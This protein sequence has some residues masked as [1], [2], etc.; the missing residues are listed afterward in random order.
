MNPVRLH[1]VVVVG[2]LLLLGHTPAVAADTAAFAFENAAN[3][4]RCYIRHN[5]FD[6]RSYW[7]ETNDL[8][9][10]AAIGD[11]Y[12]TP[13]VHTGGSTGYLLNGGN[14]HSGLQVEPVTSHGK[15]YPA[16][17]SYGAGPVPPASWL[18]VCGGLLQL[19]TPGF[20]V[21]RAPVH[22]LAILR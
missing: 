19:S 4:E 20:G 1:V 15:S 22:S 2:A 14:D 10:A 21:D 6:I 13:A 18:L 11:P 5:H 17:T 16:D 12:D 7:V 8:D 3:G 9:E